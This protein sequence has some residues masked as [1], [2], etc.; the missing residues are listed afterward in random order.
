MKK[1]F[2]LIACGLAA[3]AGSAFGME[4]DYYSQPAIFTVARNSLI[5]LAPFKKAKNT[6]VRVRGMHF[7]AQPKKRIRVKA[8]S[9]ES[10]DFDSPGIKLEPGPTNVTYNV[11]TGRWSDEENQKPIPGIEDINNQIWPDQKEFVF[12]NGG[13]PSKPAVAEP[14]KAIKK[15]TKKEKKIDPKEP[16]DESPSW[17]TPQRLLFAFGSI[18]IIGGAIFAAVQYAKKKKLKK[19]E[20]LDKNFEEQILEEQGPEAVVTG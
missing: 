2:V 9:I 4:K 16:S 11:I 14:P 15:E 3:Q 12:G 20:I 10:I 17:S 7:D 6:A 18:G 8:E 19:N 1:I 5:S 13:A